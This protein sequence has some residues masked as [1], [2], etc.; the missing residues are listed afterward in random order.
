MVTLRDSAEKLRL[1]IDLHWERLAMPL[2]ILTGLL[3]GTAI[4][5]RLIQ[6]APE[7]LQP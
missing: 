2:A 7:L 4:G 1:V 6:I 5:L 3:G